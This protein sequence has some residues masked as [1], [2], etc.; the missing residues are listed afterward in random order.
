VRPG[1][2]YEFIKMSFGIVN[3][4]ATLVRRL[5]KLFVDLKG[6]DNCIDDILVHTEKLERTH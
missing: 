2:H 5:R 3:S 6:V 1:G 4:G